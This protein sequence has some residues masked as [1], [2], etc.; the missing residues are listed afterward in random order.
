MSPRF[1]VLRRFLAAA[2]ETNVKVLRNATFSR[3]RQTLFNGVLSVE[4]KTGRSSAWL[5]RYVR[6]VEVAR[7]NRVA[8]INREVNASRFFYFL[9]FSAAFFRFSRFFQDSG[10]LFSFAFPL[11]NV[12]SSAFPPTSNFLS[13][14]PTAPPTRLAFFF[15]F[16]K[17]AYL[18]FGLPFA[19]LN[20][21]RRPR[22]PLR[23]L[24]FALFSYFFHLRQPASSTRLSFPS[25]FPKTSYLVFG[26]PFAALNAT[27]ATAAPFSPTCA[28]FLFFPFSPTG[29]T[30]PRVRLETPSKGSNP[31]T[32]RVVCG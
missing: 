7:S 4:P 19:A 2:N 25:G 20:A 17:T 31:L 30:V 12:F 26:L 18:I 13:G 22:P 8:P 16:P 28:V 6:D 14:L 27:P 21:T 29:A 15:H 3:G 1:F 5:E 23:S 32:F 9:T 11:R 24:Q 10:A